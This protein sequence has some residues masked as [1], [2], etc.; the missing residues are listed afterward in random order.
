MLQSVLTI[1]LKTHNKV[2]CSAFC[3][4]F[5]RRRNFKRI[6]HCSLQLVFW[7]C[8]E[9][10]GAELEQQLW[11]RT[12]CALGTLSCSRWSSLKSV[13]PC[14]RRC[15]GQ[16]GLQ[17]GPEGCRGRPRSASKSWPSWWSML[18]CHITLIRLFYHSL[19]MLSGSTL[20]G[21]F[22]SLREGSRV[23]LWP[24]RILPERLV[25]GWGSASAMLQPLLDNQV[26]RLHLQAGGWPQSLPCLSS[27]AR[28]AEKSR[29]FVIHCWVLLGLTRP[30][31]SALRARLWPSGPGLQSPALL[32]R[33]LLSTVAGPVSL[34]LWPSCGDH[35][36]AFPP[37]PVSSIS[38]LISY[39]NLHV[40]FNFSFS[41]TAG[42]L[43]SAWHL[44][45]LV[46]L[47]S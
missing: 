5:A 33:A 30:L 6:S 47:I 44:A 1:S 10:F 22:S 9:E 45:W 36:D 15:R 14:G 28:G 7:E 37:P 4:S 40:Y 26:R 25:Q 8:C 17:P 24:S 41:V 46:V 38:R 29:L 20:N 3:V 2:L 18:L 11:L 31:V 13:K 43:M 16:E 21:D 23:Q 27:L 35:E 19:G 12:P 32:T 34:L 42:L 39:P